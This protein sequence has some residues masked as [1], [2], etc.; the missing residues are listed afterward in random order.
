MWVAAIAVMLL[1][2]A[3][4]L[5]FRFGRTTAEVPRVEPPAA[6]PSAA[7]PVF[8]NAPPP[9]PPAEP[10]A[11]KADGPSTKK[12]LGGGGCSAVCEGQVTPALNNALRAVAQSAQGCY[13]RALRQNT[14]LSG[15]VVVAVKVRGNGASC[16]ASLVQDGL[17]DTSVASCVLQKFRSGI[18]APPVGGCADVRVPISFKPNTP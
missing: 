6:K 5:Y 2:I 1:A 14:T 12:S 4:L 7:A 8:E 9:P 17:G 18:F 15:K 3:G 10:D 16:G 13:E 11:E